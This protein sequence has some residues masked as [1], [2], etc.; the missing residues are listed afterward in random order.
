MKQVPW[1]AQDATPEERQA[2]DSLDKVTA[3]P[4]ELINESRLSRLTLCTVGDK[5]YYVKVYRHAGRYLR[6]FLGRSRVRAEWQNQLFFRTLGIPTART[7]A[8]GEHKRLG[9]Q[10]VGYIVSEEIPQTIDLW[11]LVGEQSDRLDNFEWVRDVIDRLAGYVRV[12]HHHHFVHND[13]KWRNILV[14]FSN[15]PGL[16]IIDCPLGR[17]SYGPGFSRAVVKDLACL[18][19]VAKLHL[20]RSQR[21]RFFMRYHETSHLTGTH[22]RQIKKILRFF[23]GRE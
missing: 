15:T 17:V 21:M 8:F 23:E 3:G 13:L 9:R 20:S 5:H 1:I 22:R 16:Y 10:Y 19:Q 4:G 6:R 11:R 14:D 18:D 2:F 12:M 7:V